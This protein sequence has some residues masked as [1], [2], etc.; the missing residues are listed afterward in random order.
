MGIK[1]FGKNSWNQFQGDSGNCVYQSLIQTDFDRAMR[2]LHDMDLV[3]F[4]KDLDGCMA[5]LRSMLNL[6]AWSRRWSIR[7]RRNNVIGGHHQ[8]DSGRVERALQNQT[9]RELVVSANHAD[10]LLYNWASRN[11]KKDHRPPASS[12]FQRMWNALF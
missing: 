4:W 10:I 3:C 5:D 2:R 6:P 8:A 9:L 1:K 12:F 11:Y 7:G